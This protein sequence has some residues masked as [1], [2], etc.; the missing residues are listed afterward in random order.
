MNEKQWPWMG[1]EQSL[2]PGFDFF[3]RW[4]MPAFLAFVTG[5]DFDQLCLA[6]LGAGEK[7]GERIRK[8]LSP[9]REAKLEQTLEKQKKTATQKSIRA[10]QTSLKK[11]RLEICRSSVRE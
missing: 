1:R 2:F 5:A 11:H 10:A 3:A 7:A 6:L 4:S 9:A 8:A